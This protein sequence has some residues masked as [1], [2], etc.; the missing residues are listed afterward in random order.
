MFYLSAPLI[1]LLLLLTYKQTGDAES[2]AA[3]GSANDGV[4][5]IT[6]TEVAVRQSTLRICIVLDIV[7]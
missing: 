6:T 4:T 3:D 1:V 2:D 7:R 5:T